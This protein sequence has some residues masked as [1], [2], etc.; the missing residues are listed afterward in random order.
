MKRELILA[1]NV[2][3][4]T[5][6]SD[7]NT[8]LQ[9]LIDDLYKTAGTVEDTI[10]RHLTDEEYGRLLHYAK[11]TDLDLTNPQEVQKTIQHVHAEIE[12]RPT[13]S[14]SLAF[15]P[16]RSYVKNLSEWLSIHGPGPITLAIDTN[17][18]VVAGAVIGFKGKI[19]DYS[20]K[21]VL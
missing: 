21:D 8:R 2:L 20:F 18:S 3:T 7:V 15:K 5:E 10:S 6:A 11:E 13:M 14:L 17:H 19:F 12:E 4:T 1:S 16:S 9:R